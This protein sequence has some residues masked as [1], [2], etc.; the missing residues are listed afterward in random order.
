MKSF[1][2][3][4]V[5]KPVIKVPRSG[6]PYIRPHLVRYGSIRALTKSGSGGIAEDFSPPA[7]SGPEYRP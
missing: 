4:V 1:Q 6:K 3:R 7:T 5:M 2:E